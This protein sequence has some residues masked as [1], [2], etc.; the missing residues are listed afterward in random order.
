M[1]MYVLICNKDVKS[2][3]TH[4]GRVTHICV[5]KLTNICS[6][7][8]L[9]PARRQSIIWTNAWDI[10]NWTLRNKLQW[11]F[12]RNSN[13]FIHENAFENVVCEMASILSR[14]QCD[15]QHQDY[16]VWR[17]KVRCHFPVIHIHKHCYTIKTVLC[18]SV[19]WLN[20]GRMKPST[21]PLSDLRY[22]YSRTKGAY[23]QGNS[24]NETQYFCVMIL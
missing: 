8:G 15:N 17:R 22:M 10:V 1:N 20:F 19:T 2:Y 23:R 3:I 16:T 12:N 18:K 5:G 24:L 11:N 4:W 9:S 14:P 7:N 6:D 21:G 13:I